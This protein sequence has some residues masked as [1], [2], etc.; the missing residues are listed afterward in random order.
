[1]KFRS[2]Q[3]VT[4]KGCHDYGYYV[5]ASNRVYPIIRGVVDTTMMTRLF[6]YSTIEMQKEGNLVYMRIDGTRNP[7]TEIVIDLQDTNKQYYGMICLTQGFRNTSLSLC[8]G[9][10]ADTGNRVELSFSRNRASGDKENE[11]G[12][13]YLVINR[14]GTGNFNK[15]DIEYYEVSEID[16]IREKVILNNVFSN[17]H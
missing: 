4:T 9:G 5:D 12:K 16:A 17:T 1:M 11:K 3:A 13:S 10:F 6:T 15:N 8:H 2:N 14:S 7:S